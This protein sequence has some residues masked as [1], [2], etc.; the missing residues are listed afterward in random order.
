MK[1]IGHFMKENCWIIAGLFCFLLVITDYINNISHIQGKTVTTQ[2][3][4]ISCQ[5]S[6]AVVFAGSTPV[7]Y[8]YCA[9]TVRFKT[10]SGQEIEEVVS[11][12]GLEGLLIEEG[13]TIAISYAP[14]HPQQALMTSM[15]L[16][17]TSMFCGGI[18]LI[19][20][21]A[22]VIELLWRLKRKKTIPS[23]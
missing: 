14:N 8:P 21:I 18:G 9:P 5:I 15:E 22:G 20:F 1:S 23:V 19:F 11:V 7:D 2:A 3:K 16:W 17:F 4:I 13:E 10:N 12:R 6:K